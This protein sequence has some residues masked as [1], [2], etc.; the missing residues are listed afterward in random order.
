MNYKNI[1]DTLSAVE[2]LEKRL[3]KLTLSTDALPTSALQKVTRAVIR[4][5]EDLLM[6]ATEGANMSE[7]MHKGMLV[8]QVAPD[9]TL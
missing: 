3:R 8:Y 9:I 5:L 7:L 4:G 2:E 1:Y 6:N